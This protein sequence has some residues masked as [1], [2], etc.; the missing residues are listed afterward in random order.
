LFIKGISIHG[1]YIEAIRD[2]ASLP[3]LYGYLRKKFNWSRDTFRTISWKWFKSAA[4]TYTQSHNHLM[5]LVYDQLPTCHVKHKKSGQSWIPDNCRFCDL[6]TETFEH[7][8]KCDH[9]D[10]H[11][12]RRSFP[13]AVR[14]YCESKGVPHNFQSTLVIAIEDW[15]R[16]KQPLH[17][18]R[19]RPTVQL[20][21][22][23][24]HNIGWS[25]F[26]KGFVSA[27]WRQYLEY[28]ITHASTSAETSNI[29]VDHFFVGLI[30]L[31]WTQQSQFWMTYQ[32]NLHHPPSP[33]S[34]PVQLQELKLEVEHL[35]SLKNQVPYD[36][37]HTY[38][39]SNIRQFLLSSTTSQLQTYINTYKPAILA[40]IDN[41][42]K[43]LDK[44]KTLHQFPGFF[45]QRTKTSRQRPSHR[46]GEP[47][48]NIRPINTFI[49]T[50]LH[51][52]ASSQPLCTKVLTLQMETESKHDRPLQGILPNLSYY[53]P[54]ALAHL[55]SSS[56]ECSL[57][58]TFLS[59]S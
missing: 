18:V 36:L 28:E 59:R 13:R 17:N 46:P 15:I 23:L 56:L 49:P 51:Q 52:S 33:S 9:P 20:I 8:L 1:H 44:T 40:S 45:T 50:T 53:T 16:D 25:N 24:Q 34:D 55:T 19:Q 38:F 57:H 4:K 43:Q 2:A 26:F 10:G 27:N 47:V 7:L 22:S 31:F 11:S 6:E 42:K 48:T 39:P 21:A 41:V 37:R 14:K 29:D 58:V 30:K 3:E 54:F 12:F 32:R 5:K 35:H